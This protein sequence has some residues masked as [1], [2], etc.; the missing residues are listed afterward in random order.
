MR[1]VDATG[2][3]PGSR[4]RHSINHSQLTRKKND[5]VLEGNDLQDTKA[6][7]KKIDITW[8]NNLWSREDKLMIGKLGKT[9]C[10]HVVYD[11]RQ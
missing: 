11:H 1:E 4:C 6:K 5:Q 2:V 10:A 3:L 9:R 7:I 8:F